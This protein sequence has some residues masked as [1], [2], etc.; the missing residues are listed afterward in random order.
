MSDRK[1]LLRQYKETPRQMGVY[2]IRNTANGKCFV[3]SARDVP[4]KLNGQ[5]PT[6]SGSG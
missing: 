1:D 3:G 4:G 2:C 6:R 5:P